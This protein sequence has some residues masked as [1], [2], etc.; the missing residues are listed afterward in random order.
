MKIPAELK[1][2]KDK[3][4]STNLLGDTLGTV[5]IQKQN[6]EELERV[7]KPVKALKEES[8]R[9]RKQR[10]GDGDEVVAVGDAEEAPAV[11][12]ARKE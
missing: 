5:H 8:R 12:K 3:F 1:P 10:S 9:K 7:T 4:R 11:K 6:F 2:T